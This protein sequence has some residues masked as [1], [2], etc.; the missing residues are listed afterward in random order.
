MQKQLSI[1]CH[2]N[3]SSAATT[4]DKSSSQAIKFWKT[5][6]EVVVA[7]GRLG[8]AVDFLINALL[9]FGKLN[10]TCFAKTD[11]QI[12]KGDQILPGEGIYREGNR[13]QLLKMYE[14]QQCFTPGISFGPLQLL[15]AK[16]AFASLLQ[17]E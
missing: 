12:F 1:G 16:H 7:N 17:L 10:S 5:H 3:K 8:R 14:R 11:C 9:R 6:G 13:T 15:S 4:L 2:L